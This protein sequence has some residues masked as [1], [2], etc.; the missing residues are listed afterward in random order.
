MDEKIY[1]GETVFSLD[2][3]KVYPNPE[4]P[5]KT[6]DKTLLNELAESIKKHG[7]IQP[8][9]V[10]RT[11]IGYKI[12]AGERRYRA[13]K[14]AGEKVIP[15]IVRSY[16]DRQ[17]QEVSIVEN[18]QRE[19]LNAIEEATA[20]KRLVEEFSLTQDEVAERLGKSR[21]AVANSLRLL[22][23]SPEVVRLVASDSISAGHARALVSLP[24]PQQL[25]LAQK[26]IASN[27]SVRQTEK[28]VKE[29]FA[30]EREKPIKKPSISLELRDLVER[31]QRAFGTK[32]SAVGND[33]KGRIYIDYFTR[34]DLDRLCEFVEMLEN[35]NAKE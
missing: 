6:F 34:D 3:N 5:R 1:S 8:I 35:K 12:I 18:L 28:A 20:I 4:Q 19:N 26:A 2:L 25:R 10:V 32:V 11:E 24:K 9:T 17:V 14:L 27:W 22:T 33:D 21:S 15:A 16:D 23:L 31:M 30:P 29:Y 13:C 7:V